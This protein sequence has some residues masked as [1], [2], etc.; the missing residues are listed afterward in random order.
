[1]YVLYY[2]DNPW[3]G[4]IVPSSAVINKKN[5]LILT[6][7]STGPVQ[8]Y[9]GRID[10]PVKQGWLANGGHSIRIFG[11]S[12]NISTVVYCTGRDQHNQGFTSYAEVYSGSKQHNSQFYKNS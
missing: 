12:V 4:K 8:W 1:M 5:K 6:C 11:F 10:Q 2:K 3:I 7:Y 9:V